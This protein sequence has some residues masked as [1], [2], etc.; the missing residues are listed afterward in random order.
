MVSSFSVMLRVMCLVGLGAEAAR[1]GR[2]GQLKEGHSESRW[3][4]VMEEDRVLCEEAEMQCKG[5]NQSFCEVTCGRA[6]RQAFE[7]FVDQLPDGS[8]SEG[9]FDEPASAADLVPVGQFIWD[10][11]KDNKPISNIATKHV[12]I[13]N[14]NNTNFASY[15]GWQDRM[16][17]RVTVIEA[18]SAV[19][20]TTV[21]VDMRMIFEHAGRYLSTRGR[22]LKNCYAS[23]TASVTF[24]NSLNGK[25]S[26]RDPVNTGTLSR[27]C[28][29]IDIIYSFTYG[30]W[31]AMYTDEWRF[32]YQCNGNW[33]MDPL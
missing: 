13:L 26:R 22:Y 16:S 14:K 28:A 10:F 2:T 4:G 5:G 25:A 23:P 6:P 15:S 17:D 11:I 21:K 29:R 12:S 24:G 32:R 18:K 8:D 31:L 27:P 1:R 9:I 3:A 19:G 33:W 30:S 7:G 20:L